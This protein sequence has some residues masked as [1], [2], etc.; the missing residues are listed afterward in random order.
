MKWILTLLLLFI[1]TACAS[2]TIKQSE[3]KASQMG[4]NTLELEI[5]GQKVKLEFIN[6]NYR[7]VDK[8]CM[9]EM[10]Q[11]FD[12]MITKHNFYTQRHFPSWS[13]PFDPPKKPY[14]RKMILISSVG[15]DYYLAIINN[16]LPQDKNQIEYYKKHRKKPEFPSSPNCVWGCIREYK[17]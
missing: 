4:D 2:D 14:N 12:N 8:E 5:K 15:Q 6:I 9:R 7:H 17:L 16:L 11:H 1:T 3:T 10:I 13:M